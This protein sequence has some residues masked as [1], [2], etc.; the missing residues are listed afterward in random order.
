MGPAAKEQADQYPVLILPIL[1]LVLGSDA[2]INRGETDGW[3]DTQE[4]FDHICDFGTGITLHK[5]ESIFYGIIHL[6]LP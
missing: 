2:S 4:C 3:T 5:I 1:C 6:F